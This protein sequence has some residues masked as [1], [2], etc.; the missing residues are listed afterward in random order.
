M[1]A[2]TT[3]FMI[4]VSNRFIH[5]EMFIPINLICQIYNNFSYIPKNF[6]QK[7]F[8]TLPK[9]EKSTFCTGNR[10]R[11]YNCMA[12]KTTAYAKFRHTGIFAER[13]RFELTDLLDRQFS[14]LLV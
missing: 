13:V 7:N 5:T 4:G 10:I 3:T 14:K 2:W 1:G 12:S 8:W 6:P 11:T 9:I